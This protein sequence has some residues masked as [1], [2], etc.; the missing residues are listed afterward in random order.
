MLT[1]LRCKEKTKKDLKLCY[2]GA[3]N[4]RVFDFPEKFK[5]KKKKILF[6]LC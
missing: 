3:I 4:F 1:N 5:R 2:S 6:N